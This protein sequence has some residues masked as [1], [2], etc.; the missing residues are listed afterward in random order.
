MRKKLVKNSLMNL[1]GAILPAIVGLLTIPYIVRSMGDATYGILTLVT[2]IIGYFAILDLN[3]SSGAIKYIAEYNAL[4]KVSE[5]NQVIT[6]GGMV[7]FAIGLI[8]FVGIYFFSDSLAQTV[9]SVPPDLV[10]LAIS[11]IKLAAFGFIFGQLQSYL[12]SIPQALQRYTVAAKM[13]ASFG[14]A[15]PLLTVIILWMG[16]GLYEVVLLRVLMSVAN[17]VLLVL[18]IR[19]LMPDLHMQMPSR[20]IM[21]KLGSFSMFAYLSKIAS[22]IYTN[23]DK[24]I[25]GALIGMASLTYYIIPFTLINR[26]L[27]MSF[28]L[29]SVIYPAASE[30]NS[31][32]ELDKLK[33]IYFSA[34]KYVAY[35]NLY[36]LLIVT[37][38]AHEILYYW[39][40]PR[41]ADNGT[42]VMVLIALGLMLDS[43][44]NIPSLLN[45]GFG[46]PKVTGS[47]AICRGLVG[48]LATF[49]FT[50]HFGIVGAAW[51]HLLASALLTSAFLVY[52][53]KRT[54]PYKLS[55]LL[56]A[57]YLNITIFVLIVFL[58]FWL[59]KPSGVMV[60][61]SV[62]ESAVL[63]LFLFAAYGYFFVLDSEHRTALIRQAKMRLVPGA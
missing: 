33:E 24:L 18:V 40:G 59:L 6:F 16:Y 21:L 56:R 26:I 49:I 41:Y 19:N 36:F 53:H 28:R 43:V 62:I 61:S 58:I 25:I 44:T 9:F 15:I 60:L 51:G 2:A 63:L 32:N 55:E 34:T 45:D 14:M 48:L 52:A 23:A 7:Y 20:H 30:M 27:S 42:V 1:L 29:S 22:I 5:L 11:T 54:I 31:K 10:L 3:I 12:I 38:F 57:S 47:F 8:G 17:V 46:H 4:S 37:I 35:I 13:E 39:M 50:K